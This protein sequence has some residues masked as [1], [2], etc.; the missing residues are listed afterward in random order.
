MIIF[1]FVTENFLL[2][3]KIVHNTDSADSIDI[4]EFLISATYV[5]LDVNS[6]NITDV[7]ILLLTMIITLLIMLITSTTTILMIQ[8]TLLV[9][10]IIMIIMIITLIIETLD[11][12]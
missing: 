9:I 2:N 7:N 3:C 1:F 11:S 10:L 12:F 4:I 8:I 5:R 6:N